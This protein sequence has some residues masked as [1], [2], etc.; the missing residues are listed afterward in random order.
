MKKFYMLALIITIIYA[1]RNFLID[2][3]HPP[4]DIN[5]V[6]EVV[7]EESVEIDTPMPAERQEIY[8]SVED[9]IIIC[10]AYVENFKST[11]YFD[12]SRWTIGYGST[13][14]A[15][16]Q[17]VQSNQSIS[18]LNAQKCARSHLRKHV[19]PYIDKHVKR[20][21]TRQEIIGTSMFIYNIGAGNF[22]KSSFLQAVND[23]ETPYDCA[24]K[25]TEF[26]KAS[27]NFAPGLLKREWVQGA[28]YCGY[29]T[30]YDILELTPAGFYNS[31]L[32]DFYKTPQRNWDGFYNLDYSRTNVEEF[33]RKNKASGK[34]V[35]D[36]V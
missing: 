8:L 26:T 32:E 36:I 15:N 34:K 2:C 1:N 21:L 22:Q 27:G 13:F 29:I 10:L 19:F 6:C 31:G 4:Q 35:L 30:P 14:Y 24:R 25:M 7:K 11:S 16:G 20:P 18:M 12:G 23:G 17:R 5:N 9:E 3:Q 28:V 33:L